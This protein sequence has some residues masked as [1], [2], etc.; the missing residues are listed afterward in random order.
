M[1]EECTS[2]LIDHFLLKLLMPLWESLKE[3][4]NLPQK[5][6]KHKT[7]LLLSQ[8]SIVKDHST[9]LLKAKLTSAHGNW[10]DILKITDSTQDKMISKPFWEELITVEINN[11]H[12]RNSV[13]LLKHHHQQMKLRQ[14][15]RTK[16]R[17]KLRVKHKKKNKKILKRMLMLPHQN[18][19]H[20]KTNQIEDPIGKSS[21]MREE[22][23]KN[24]DV[25]NG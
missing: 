7:N 5:D 11:F 16:K 14:K 19:N 21:K 8:I 1:E 4:I 2:V 13:K 22:K 20:W 15:Q 10:L 24:S 25:N 23:L 9:E 12:S 18:H 17:Q 6:W 3:S